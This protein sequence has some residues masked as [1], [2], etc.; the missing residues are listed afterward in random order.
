MSK[1]MKKLREEMCES[2]EEICKQLEK[3]NQDNQVS[4]P[5][6]LVNMNFSGYNY[7]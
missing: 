3:V 7:T 6:D 5:F 1:Q 4:I 2:K